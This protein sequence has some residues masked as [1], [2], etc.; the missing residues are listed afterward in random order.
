MDSSKALKYHFKTFTFVGLWPKS[1]I[2]YPFL[3]IFWAVIVWLILGIFYPLSLILN[4]I[5]AESIFE[6]AERLVITSSVVVLVIKAINLISNR[7]GLRQLFV[8]L[9]ELDDGISD[10]LHVAEMQ[11]VIQISHRLYFSFLCS[12]IST[13]VLLVFQ[14]IFSKPE[15]RMWSST[16]SY[17]YDW[18]HLSYVY[19]SGIFFQ[20]ISNHCIVVFAVAADTY[21]V[22]LIHIL[23]AHINILHSRLERLGK[24]VRQSGREQYYDLIYCCKVYEKIL[25]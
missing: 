16:Y 11:S 2:R 23:A 5:F 24:C 7:N 22:I 10:E 13:C 12:Y 19:V 21:G 4:L 8:Q 25:R 1:S 20:G 17:P 3:Y 15:T 9:K 6:M 14:A 18:A